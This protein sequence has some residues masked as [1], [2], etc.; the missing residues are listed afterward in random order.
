[1]GVKLRDIFTSL[2]KT[3]EVKREEAMSETFKLVYNEPEKAIKE[4]YQWRQLGSVK[5]I[6]EALEKATEEVLKYK[7][8]KELTDGFVVEHYKISKFPFI[9]KKTKKL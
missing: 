5:E 4:I 8:L 7:R 1:M 6:Q 2:F 3:K 9:F